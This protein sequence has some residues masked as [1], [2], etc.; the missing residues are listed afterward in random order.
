ML[1]RTRR[2]HF[3]GVGGSGMSGIAELLANLGYAVTGSDEKRSP[4]TDRLASLGVKVDVGH[5][6]HHV[7]GADVVEDAVHDGLAQV[8]LERA[9][10]LDVDAIEPLERLQH[11]VLYQI[12]GLGEISCPAGQPAAGPASQR[13]GVASEESVEGGPIALLC[14]G[15]QLHRA[16]RVGRRV[17]RVSYEILTFT[18]GC[19]RIDQA[20][21]GWTSP[22]AIEKTCF[23]RHAISV[24]SCLGLRR[25]DDRR[26]SNPET[27]SAPYLVLHDRPTEGRMV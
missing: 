10:V 5:A 24:R 16:R 19:Y 17:P 20:P 18:H 12:V 13:R 6:A 11:R 8:G 25:R 7:G 23:I 22:N 2:I 21:P 27:C 14:K 26:R 3:I 15:D 1:G 9:F 4:A